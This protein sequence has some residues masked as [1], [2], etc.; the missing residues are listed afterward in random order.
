[1]RPTDV[2]RAEHDHILRACAVLDAMAGKLES[3]AAVDAADAKAVT[4]FVRLY[5]DGL[6][7]AKEE[8]VLFP[9]MEAAGMPRNGGPIA[10]MLHDHETGRA[11]VAGM[12][13]AVE[14]G[15]D[16]SFAMHARGFASLLT[17]HIAKENNVLFMMASRILPES[18]DERILAAYAEREAEARKVCGEKSTHEGKLSELSQRWL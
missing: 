5:A 13:A 1:M 10:V 11:H 16:A 14:N 6:H 18:S 9:A 15:V 7:H 8:H 17:Q 3:G 12:V 2:L 4:D